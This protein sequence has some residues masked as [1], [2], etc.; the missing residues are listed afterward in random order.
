MEL[1]EWLHVFT[2]NTSPGGITVKYK[3]SQSSTVST[4]VLEGHSL[5]P[6]RICGNSYK[7][8]SL[9]IT[10]NF[11]KSIRVAIFPLRSGIGLVSYDYLSNEDTLVYRDQFV[12]TQ[13]FPNCSFMYFTGTREVVGY[14]LDLS[15]EPAY[16]YS[17]RIGI[18]YDNL[19]LSVLKQH[20]VGERVK[21]INFTSLSNFVYFDFNPNHVDHCFSNEA[22][23]V[24]CL[25]N[26]EVLDHGFSDERFV[27]K[28]LH[29]SAC[30]SV[31]RLLRVGMTCKLVA[32]CD[33]NVF[34]FEVHQDQPT[35]LSN[36]SSGQVFVC[37]DLQTVKLA[38]G[39][40]S[41]HTDIGTW[42]GMSIPFPLERIRQGDCFIIDG[43]YLFFATLVDGRTLLSNFTS[44]SYRQLGA[45][46]HATYVPSMVKGQIGLVHDENETLVYNLSLPCHE[47]PTV[48]PDS[49]I[50][51]NY[52]STGAREQ[53]WCPSDS[54][55]SMPT[56]I[57]VSQPTTVIY[58]TSVNDSRLEKWEVLLAV[59]LPVTVVVV[60]PLLCILTTVCCVCK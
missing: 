38:N 33:D 13:I 35:V 53:C 6:P 43:H 37:T 51:A 49:F 17:L 28:E 26:G 7:R 41:L 39:N 32:Y 5:P 54:S 57:P 11:D 40:L 16:M 55:P 46:E 44:A 4:T 2:V 45:S 3:N 18:Q 36:R 24:V 25:E 15:A 56:S 60:V 27:F 59:I 34:L 58:P 48:I 30:S 22:G 9:H 20:N 19:S 29:I 8:C 47:E 23:H 10:S 31:S 42:T 50:L 14:C 52:F 1:C 12:L 21:L